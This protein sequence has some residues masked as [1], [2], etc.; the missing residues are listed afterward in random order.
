MLCLYC[1]MK[2][3]NVY[4]NLLFLS[5]YRD[6]NGNL[7]ELHTFLLAFKRGG[8]RNKFDRW[9]CQTKYYKR[10][11]LFSSN[12]RRHA[13]AQLFKALCYKPE[14]RGFDSRWCRRNFS[15][16]K[17]FRPNYGPWVVSASNRNA[18]Q[19]YF[20]GSKG[21]RCIGQTILPPSCA[22]CHEIW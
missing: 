17:S 2:L 7:R 6:V 5:S 11:K 4:M 8:R 18:Y 9:T 10:H 3:V 22:Y 15:L 16:H 1:N 21:N 12:I 20:L 14:G 19:E 13:V